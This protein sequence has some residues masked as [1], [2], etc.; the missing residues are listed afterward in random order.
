MLGST[1]KDLIDVS[2]AET[3]SIIQSDYF[4]FLFKH[5]NQVNC[6]FTALHTSLR[7]LGLQSLFIALH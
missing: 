6:I 2:I 5:I 1:Q 4:F 7:E 3:F